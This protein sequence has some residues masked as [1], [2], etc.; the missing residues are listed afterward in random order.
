MVDAQKIGETNTLNV[1]EE[2][3]ILN[4]ENRLRSFIFSSIPA[5]PAFGV[6]I[7]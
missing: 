3:D 5:A 2:P 6:Y 1:W 4:G 7:S